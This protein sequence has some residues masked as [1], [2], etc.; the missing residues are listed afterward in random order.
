MLINGIEY[1]FCLTTEAGIKIAKICP[2]GDILKFGQLLDGKDYAKAAE[3]LAAI[4]ESLSEGYANKELYENG[5]T[6]P[7]LTKEELHD[8]ILHSTLFKYNEMNTEI[9]LAMIRDLTGEV[10][11][12][13]APGKPGKKEKTGAIA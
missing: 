11:A 6:V 2:D 5:R 8:V 12:E 3:N 4:A 9:V 7:R 1:E 10:E 13:E